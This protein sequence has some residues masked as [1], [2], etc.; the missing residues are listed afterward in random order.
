M[1]I[2]KK[3][4]PVEAARVI[5][6]MEPRPKEEPTGS[7]FRLVIQRLSGWTCEKCG[8]KQAHKYD[9]ACVEERR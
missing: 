5:A 2:L 7:T 1:A 4:M 6:S 9:P 3:L 8:H